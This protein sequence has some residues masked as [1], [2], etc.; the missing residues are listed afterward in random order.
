MG[1]RSRVSESD[2]ISKQGLLISSGFTQTLL[3]PPLGGVRDNTSDFALPVITGIVIE[4][5]F[6]GRLGST[7]LISTVIV[8]GF[9]TLKGPPGIMH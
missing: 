5:D 8:V 1:K 2:E 7:G 3:I 4:A 6:T 9:K